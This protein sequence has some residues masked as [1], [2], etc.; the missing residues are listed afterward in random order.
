MNK[1]LWTEVKICI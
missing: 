1:E